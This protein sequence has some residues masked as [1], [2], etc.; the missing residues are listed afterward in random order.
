MASTAAASVV[1]R[2]LKSIARKSILA[3]KHVLGDLFRR[4]LILKFSHRGAI[5]QVDMPPHHRGKGRLIALPDKLPQQFNI[6]F[7]HSIVRL[8]LAA[9]NRNNFA[10]NFANPRSS[11]KPLTDAKLLRIVNGQR[12][13]R[14][15]TADAAP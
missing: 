5:N 9:G 15:R 11:G 4:G 12:Y 13:R 2:P 3:S 6:R 10:P 7:V 14:D 8:P 1:A